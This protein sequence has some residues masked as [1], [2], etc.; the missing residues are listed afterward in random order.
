ML[1][2][3]LIG[4]FLFNTSKPKRT[5]KKNRPAKKGKKR[6]SR[7]M[8]ESRHRLKRSKDNL[9]SYQGVIKDWDKFRES[10]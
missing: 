5:T 8:T 3:I 7:H 2:E 6:Q 9:K 1:A 10:K 4:T